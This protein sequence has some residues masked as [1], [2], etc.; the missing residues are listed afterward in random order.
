MSRNAKL[1]L[2]AVV[3]FT[4]V[5]VVIRLSEYRSYFAPNATAYLAKLS[6]IFFV[7]IC[8]ILL[9]DRLHASFRIGVFRLALICGFGSGLLEI[10]TIAGENDAF[11]FRVPQLVGL[12]SV[13]A[14][15]SIA[16]FWATLSLRSVKAGLLTSVAGAGVC[17]LIGVAGGVAV[18]MFVAPTNP[19]LVATWQEFKRSAWTD[20]AAFQIAN[21]LDSAFSHLLL[22]PVVAIVVGAVGAGLGKLLLI[23][24]TRPAS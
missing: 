17:M 3:L 5:L 22:A 8:A 9:S 12:L 23:S 1:G 7:Y 24:Q 4:C 6:A 19:A 2:I 10:S 11:P 14:T 13:F 21:T 20:P 16:G 18:E 15:W